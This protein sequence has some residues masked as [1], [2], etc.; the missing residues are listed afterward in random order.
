M[1]IMVSIFRTPQIQ[2][3]LD[4]LADPTI[5]RDIGVLLS[6]LVCA[7]ALVRWIRGR[8]VDADSIWF[9]KRIFDGV[10]FPIAALGLAY[11]A[12][13]VLL[14][15]VKPAVFKV[16]I[17]ALLALLVIRL[18]V[19]VLSA[20]FPDSRW[21]RR[22][23]RN[24]SWIAWGL[25]VLWV[26]GILP[27]ILD[28]ME[29]IR[30]KIGSAHLTLRNVVEGT[31]TT[32]VVLMLTLWA[33]SA[34]EKKLL[35]GSG[36]NLSLRK[37]AANLIRVGLLFIGLM[38]ALSS[39]GIDLTALSVLSGAVGVGMGLGLQRIA[40]NY[41]SG[42]VILAERSL[43]IGDMV[44]VDNFEGRISDIRT[45]F[46]VIRA[47]NGREAVVPN[48]ILLTQR[49]ENSSLA[50]PKVS[51]NTVFQI[52]YGSNV[53]ALQSRLE[54]EISEVDRVL[55]DPAPAL[56]L[57]EFGADGLTMTLLFWISDPENGPGAVK[58]AVNLKVLDVLSEMGI[59]IPYPQRE[60]HLHSSATK[61]LNI[62]ALQ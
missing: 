28:A 2:E 29:E 47:L 45:R 13:A 52:A 43:R 23:E 30:W 51:L 4:T 9:G 53:R 26:M 24:I 21:L 38:L 16:A 7:W 62:R 50:D 32:S 25:M 8:S 46:T 11:G 37:M 33:S 39:V 55:R 10:L 6:C 17:P 49:V 12:K 1:N 54:Q 42:F 36:D 20:T 22:I 40:A 48:E 14:G 3:L 57:T 15:V 59:T 5:L 41:V 35:R 56:Q 19:R 61:T 44:K 34:I 18:S 58:S 31:L 60:L 27:S